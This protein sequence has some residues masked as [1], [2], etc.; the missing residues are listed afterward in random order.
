MVMRKAPD[1]S[2]EPGAGLPRYHVIDRTGRSTPVALA[3]RI[4]V[5]PDAARRRQARPVAELHVHAALAVAPG[6]HRQALDV[7]L[8]LEVVE[9]PRP[10]LA[11]D[12]GALRLGLIAGLGAGLLPG[13]RVAVDQPH[14][15]HP[16]AGDELARPHRAVLG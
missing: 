9:D 8:G 4:H 12:P 10:E 3:P 1:R 6:E 5:E 16:A 15:S 2:P 7:V 14:R 13:L 11:E